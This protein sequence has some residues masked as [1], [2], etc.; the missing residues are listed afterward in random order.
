MAD[1]L[2]APNDVEQWLMPVVVG[3]SIGIWM[4]LCWASSSGTGSGVPAIG[5]PSIN[6]AR[7]LNSVL[8]F[9]AKSLQTRDIS[10]GPRI[11]KNNA[12]KLS[13][14][15]DPKSGATRRGRTIVGL[16]NRCLY[17]SKETVDQEFEVGRTTVRGRIRMFD[18]TALDVNVVIIV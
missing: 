4:L 11:N 16:Q 6:L 2:L 15:R 13:T 8:S 5:G 18:C 12:T 9:F 14:E 10:S 3:S 1:G 17:L 7:I